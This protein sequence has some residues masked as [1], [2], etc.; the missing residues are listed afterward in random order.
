MTRF[1]GSTEEGMAPILSARYWTRGTQL[2]GVVLG[3]FNTQNGIC[4]TIKLSE[5]LEISGELVS[6]AQ[7]GNVTLQAVSVGGLKGFEAALSV[8]GIEALQRGDKVTIKCV[9]SK[10]T[11]QQSDM[12]LFDID[13]DRPD[14]KKF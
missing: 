12:V 11:G 10:N 8:A 9:G 4:T 3:R 13:V 7:D 2:K 6:P 14:Q 1:H 5:P